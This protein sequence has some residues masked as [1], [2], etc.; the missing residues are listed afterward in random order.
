MMT[1]SSGSSSALANRLLFIGRVRVGDGFEGVQGSSGFFF[2]RIVVMVLRF[3]DFQDKY[4]VRILDPE[5][6]EHTLSGGP[7]MA[8]V[9]S[10]H[11]CS[12]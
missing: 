6:M 4:P 11:R 3:I 9:S 1:H 2:D 5:V 10:T 7:G 8:L 12:L